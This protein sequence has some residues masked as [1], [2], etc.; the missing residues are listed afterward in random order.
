M[1]QS[2]RNGG[3]RRAPRRPFS[4]LA[5]GVGLLLAAAPVPSAFAD[6]EPDKA[7]IA[8]RLQR[9]TEAFNARDAT[10]TCDL[11]A[12]DLV[13]SVRG[14]PDRGRDAICAQI[15]AAL[16]HPKRRST[17]AA[18]IREILVS[19]NLAVVRLVWTLNVQTGE[20]THTSQEPGIDVF[21]REPNGSWAIIRYLAFST[22]NE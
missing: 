2:K 13:A 6:V 9:W 18:E 12:P 20:A 8:A 10:R 22:D 4:W 3:S 7:A 5:A 14:A 21:R 11:F 19:G 1:G 15:A 16:A 17:Y